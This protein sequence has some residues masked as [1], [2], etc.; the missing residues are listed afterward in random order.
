MGFP[1]GLVLIIADVM[2]TQLVPVLLHCLYY[3]RTKYQKIA[4]SDRNPERMEQVL[5][6]LFMRPIFS[7]RQLSLALGSNYPTA[8]RY[9]VKLVELGVLHEITGY[10]RNRIFRADEI[11]KTLEGITNPPE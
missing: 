1:L 7:I 4:D 2:I 6:F 11:F 5:D 3:L 10:A 8:Q 9:I